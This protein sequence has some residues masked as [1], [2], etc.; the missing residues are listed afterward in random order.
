MSHL[1]LHP[2]P[3]DVVVVGCGAGGSVVA[4]ELGEAGISVVVLDAGR[5]FD[6]ERDYRSDRPDFPAGAWKVFEPE[7]PRRDLYTA[8][9][10]GFR[11]VRVKGIGGTTVVSWGV[12]PRFHESDFQVRS[13]DG[14]A[15]DWPITYADLEPYYARVEYELGMSGPDGPERN[16]FD[17]PRSTPFPTP[18]HRM[19]RAGEIIAQG[20]RKLGLHPFVPALAIPTKN[21]GG[22]PA[23]IEAGVCGYGCRIS[24]KSSAD[25][26]YVRKAEATGRVKILDSCTARQIPID[27]SNRA[28]GVVYFD[29]AGREQ[30]VR[31][32]AVV[33]AANAIETPRLLLLSRSRLYPEGLANSS[34]LVGK[35]LTEHLDAGCRVRFSLPLKNW[36]GVPVS[37]MIQ[38]YYET[39]RT[40]PFA[41]GWLLEVA[42]TSTWP[43]A[44]ARRVG[45][46]GPTHKARVKELFG[47]VL[48]VYAQGEQLPDS[49]NRVSLDP[50]V[51][52]QYGLAVPHIESAA[53]GND[54][55]MLSAMERSIREL[56]LA[57]GAEELLES[58]THKPGASIHYMGTCRM[59]N[60]PRTSVVNRWGRTH[61]V[62]N[63]FIADSSVFVTGAAAHPTL[64]LMALASRT[65]DFLI[66]AFRQ[67]EFSS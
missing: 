56:V 44:V 62:S 10:Q 14:V 35:Y 67:G 52:D 16:P 31:A 5:R 17:S 2:D 6:P 8:G 49:R 12:S 58:W 32:R 25:V 26:T 29:R 21:W 34:G 50:A 36:E 65:A 13:R 37:T 59:G 64:T 48:E 4:K 33:L 43:I 53:R 61:E 51:T 55:A 9:P 41:R 46:W 47:H 30:E 19:T 66:E 23:C 11:Y 42:T 40:N 63:L 28:R 39:R 7:D 38:D 57:A 18:P 22:R 54:V 60:D 27:S 20:A 15:D 45:G 3:V 1:L 24:A